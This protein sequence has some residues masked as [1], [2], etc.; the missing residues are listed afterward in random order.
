MSNTVAGKNSVAQ[1]QG[2]LHFPSNP[3]FS[4]FLKQSPLGSL[5]SVSSSE[6]LVGN[7][8]DDH[9]ALFL[10]LLLCRTPFFLPRLLHLH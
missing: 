2:R 9:L 10:A 6:L 3:V 7:F 5:V 4:S 8:F 1:I